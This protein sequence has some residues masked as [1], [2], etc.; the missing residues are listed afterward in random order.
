MAADRLCQLRNGRSGLTDHMR[1]AFIQTYPIYHDMW[2]TEQWLELQNRDKWMPGIA[3]S[4]GH[5]VE[6][7]A[8]DQI[9]STHYCTMP[10]FGAF[11]IRLFEK[12]SGGSKSKFHYSD[13]L[14]EFARSYE[15]DLC[16][17]KGVDGGAGIRLFENYL[18]SEKRRTA[19]VIGGKAYNRYIQQA[20]AVFYETEHQRRMLLN[21][22]WRFWRR[23]PDPG[24]LIRLAKSVDTEHFRPMPEVKKEWDIIAVCRLSPIKNPEAVCKLSNV[25]KVAIAGTGPLEN[26]LRTGYPNVVWL[27]QVPNSRLPDLL[28][29]ARVLVHPGLREFYPR[30]LTEAAACGIP[31]V[32]FANAIAPDVLPP[33]T[34]IRVG[35]NVLQ[36]EVLQLLQ[37]PDRLN[38]MGEA[39]RTYAVSTVG[40]YAARPALEELFNLLE[41]KRTQKL[42]QTTADD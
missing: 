21:P 33:E 20:S 10:G 8:V 3:A 38:R 2:T 17:L 16:I 36:D 5:E 41:H 29:R 27:G 11:T 40:R 1:I 12:T 22:A 37:Q 9:S 18:R 25:A 34:G 23:T 26:R 28:N 39:G 4:M 31:C 6:L 13:H 14:V 24:R 42:L 32:A 19:W 35:Q 30:V 7:W 15:P